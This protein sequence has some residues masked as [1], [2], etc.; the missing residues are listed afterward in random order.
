[1]FDDGG[2]ICRIWLVLRVRAHPVVYLRDVRHPI[3][4]ELLFSFCP[5]IMLALRPRRSPRFDTWFLFFSRLIGTFCHKISLTNDR[6][7]NA[8]PQVNSLFSAKHSAPL[9]SEHVIAIIAAFPP[10]SIDIRFA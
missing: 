2:R 7:K 3:N 8:I 4:E 5:E 1:M 9:T 10:S 6:F